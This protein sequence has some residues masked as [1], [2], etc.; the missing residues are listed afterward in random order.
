LFGAYTAVIGLAIVAV[1]GAAVVRAQFADQPS[2]YWPGLLV[3]AGGQG[4]FWLGIVALAVHSV[5]KSRTRRAGEYDS[6]RL[7]LK[8]L[9]CA[10]ASAS[11]PAAPRIRS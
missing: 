4:V 1:G 6:L 7:E 8:Q 2:L 5:R 10:M 9:R 11:P 3:A